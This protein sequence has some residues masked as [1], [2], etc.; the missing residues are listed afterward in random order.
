MAILF[1]S[2]VIMFCTLSLFRTFIF[3]NATQLRQ[4]YRQYLDLYQQDLAGGDVI[5]SFPIIIN[6][7]GH[8]A[9]SF[10]PQP[11]EQV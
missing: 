4:G 5:A 11:M 2:Y 6:L 9:C 8:I 1:Q 10:D 7:N 3:V